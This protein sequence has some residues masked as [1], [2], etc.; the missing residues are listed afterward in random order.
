LRAAAERLKK[1][2]KYLKKKEAVVVKE[3]EKVKN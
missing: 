1:L 3:K 2:S